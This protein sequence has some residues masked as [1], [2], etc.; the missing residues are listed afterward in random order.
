MP[1][2]NYLSLLVSV[3]FVLSGCSGSGVI[4]ADDD[5][6]TGDD[7]ITDD[8]DDDTDDDD[9]ATD[10]DDDDDITEEFTAEVEILDIHME[11][12]P[13]PEEPPHLVASMRFTF[14]NTY[15]GA[16]LDTVTPRPVRILLAADDTEVV[17]ILVEPI[18]HWDQIV[19]ADSTVTVDYEMTGLSGPPPDPHDLPCDAEVY[20]EAE[21]NYGSGESVLAGSPPVIFDCGGH[22]PDENVPG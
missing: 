19:P 3:L 17:S 10:D 6:L 21:V 11:P 4:V 9:D 15:E 5:D 1:N 12:S 2:V 16:V 8:D 22:D 13:V 20:A 7:D 18:D 14:I